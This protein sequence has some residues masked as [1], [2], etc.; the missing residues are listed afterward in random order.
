M[1]QYHHIG[2]PTTE[3]RE[4]EV[5]VPHLKLFASGYDTSEYRIEYIR[6]AEGSEA[7]YHP[8]MMKI[9]HVAFQVDDLEKELK[10]KKLIWGPNESLPGFWVAFILEND[11]L[12]ELIQTK[13]TEEELVAIVQ[14]RK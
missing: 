14:S 11:F 1:R 2:I 8:L 12:V 4:G 10:G 13:L 3:K 9:P 7:L 6:Y 5:Y